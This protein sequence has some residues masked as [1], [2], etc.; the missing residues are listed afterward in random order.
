MPGTI[1]VVVVLSAGELHCPPADAAIVAMRGTLVAGEQ[2]LVREVQKP[3]DDDKLVALRT[4]TASSAVVEIAWSHPDHASVHLHVGTG[5]RDF[6]DRDLTFTASDQEDE[7]GRTVGLVLSSMLEGAVAAGRPTPAPRALRLVYGLDL[8]IDVAHGFDVD[9]GSF[10]ARLGALLR[11]DEGWLRASSTFRLGSSSQADAEVLSV[12][13][14][15]GGAGVLLERARWRVALGADV[16]I[17]HQWVERHRADGDITRSRWIFEVSPFL[18]A[19]YALGPR[20]AFFAET[21]PLLTLPRTRV[22]VGDEDRG[23]LSLIGWSGGA[24]ARFWF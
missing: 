13:L 24:G 18:H 7:R 12:R 6:A 20:F 4:S 22:R 2:V 14:A 5:G 1:V 17:G 15:V 10:G 21:G 8:A 3:L 23:T 16:A 9:E 19:S 11:F